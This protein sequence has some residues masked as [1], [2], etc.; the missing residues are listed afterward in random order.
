[1]KYLL[2]NDP[3]DLEITFTEEVFGEDGTLVQQVELKPGGRN[4]VVNKTNCRAYLLLLAYAIITCFV[5]SLMSLC[6]MYLVG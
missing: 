5:T 2:E 1:M 4:I 6:A 3:A